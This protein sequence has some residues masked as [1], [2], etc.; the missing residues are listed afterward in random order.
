MKR[1]M[2]VSGTAI[3]L[4]SA[5]LVLFETGALPILLLSAVSVFII[6]F[7]KPLRL[8]E[9]IIIPTIC[10]SII[11]SCLFFGIYHFTKIA[12]ATKLDNTI[13]TI[14][15]KIITT[16]QETAYGTK[17]TLKA[18]NSVGFDK[19]TNI[20]IL[21]KSENNIDVK[22]YDYIS[23][24]DTQLKIIRN[25][26]NKPDTSSIGDGVIL[27]AQADSCE[28]LWESEKTPYYFC[29]R[30]KEIVTEQI[31]AYLPEY[32]TGVLLG[33]L[34]GDK[35]ELDSDIVND[36]RAT[37][38]AHL[39]AVSG[40]HTSTWCAYIIILLKLL[41]LK[42]KT[43][44]IFCVLF[45]ILLCIV[46]AFTPSVMRASI[47]M[48]VVL[49]APFFNE[50]QD[51]FNSLGFAVSILTL[52]NPYIITSASFLLSVSATLGVLTSLQLY[53]KLRDRFLK[54]KNT[55]LKNLTG[56]FCASLLST[57]LAGLFTLPFSAYFF[58]IFSLVSP[59]VNIICVKPA[60]WSMLTGVVA[61]LISFLPQNIPQLISIFIFKISGLFANFV[62]AFANIF[63]DF[64]FCTLPI[65]KEYFIL[66]VILMALTILIGLSI[67][68]KK[69]SKSTK[70]IIIGLCIAILSCG[71]LLP[72][73]RLAPATLYITNVE[74]GINVTLRQ[75]LKYAHL[76]CGT[77]D[78]NTFI[79]TLPKSKS[80]YL[81]FLYIGKA[82]KA[83]NKLTE[84]I[85]SH[86]PETTVIS[87]YAKGNLNRSGIQ[88]PQN[89]IIS[90][91]YTHNFNKEITIQ[92]V[93]TY[94][95]NCVIIKCNEKI[96]IICY[97][98]DY[99]IVKIF[100]SYGKPDILVLPESLPK[101]LP[102]DIETLIISSNS[103]AVIRNDL[104][105]L[106]RQCKNFYT[107]TENGDVKISL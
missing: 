57:T 105:V 100:S 66:T 3:G 106:E 26:Y 96:V 102:H 8:K 88:L 69:N 84:D 35:T 82:D 22:L 25:E 15:G 33:M 74:N 45:L 71:S 39:L 92:I 12:P 11:A 41:R 28:F 91:S 85:I 99:D 50:E 55:T 46:S 19:S 103:E 59:V 107:T 21:I 7:I 76:N 61:T 4:S 2:L 43:R 40:L 54:I 95:V 101:E 67:I 90:D 68:K 83:T 31:N 13:T 79:S 32:N 48:A 30:L 81:D 52:N 77:T 14:S 98:S 104:S 17:F 6:Y 53:W 94:P 37:G 42:E 73:T 72:C 64:I 29:L 56:Y 34:F 63:E 1:P 62:T 65:H 44:N 18:D 10:I 75:G 89:T 70:G 87:E 23:I 51:P 86:K 80:E 60:F 58:G 36:F 20:Q 16:P 49:F 9:K 24:P 47:M 93:D 27:E 5:I 78:E 97:G 38:I